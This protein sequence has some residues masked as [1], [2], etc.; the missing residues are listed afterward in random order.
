MALQKKVQLWVV[1]VISFVLFSLLAITGLINWLVL[2]H[3]AGRRG[4]LLIQTR[5]LIRDVHAWAAVF[6]LAA[7]VIHLML[8]WP[9]V[10]T[11]LVN[12]GWLGKK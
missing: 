5:H 9:Y 12:M 7:V 3:G 10:R 4:D 6:F 11:N 8:H 2:P 1:N